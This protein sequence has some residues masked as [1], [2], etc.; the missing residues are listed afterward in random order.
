MLMTVPLTFVAA[1]IVGAATSLIRY[2]ILV[3]HRVALAREY[4]QTLLSVLSQLQKGYQLEHRAPDGSRWVLH[5]STS[6]P[7]G[8][9]EGT[10]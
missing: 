4:D 6:A 5:P 7:A 10:Q 2:W 3:W 8:R 1:T 9:G